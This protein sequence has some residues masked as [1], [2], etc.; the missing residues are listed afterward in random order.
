MILVK[1]SSKSGGRKWRST[2][3]LFNL[4][5]WGSEYASEGAR[6]ASSTGSLAAGF[7]K[8]LC[9]QQ[10]SVMTEYYREYYSSWRSFLLSLSL[11]SY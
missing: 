9:S 1:A 6:G 3:S 11:L 10:T 4:I 7:K 8:L 5:I 2:D